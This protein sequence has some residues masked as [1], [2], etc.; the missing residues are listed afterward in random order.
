VRSSSM[1][2]ACSGRAVSSRVAKLVCPSCVGQWVAT[3]FV[4]GLVPRP[5]ATRLVASVFA[6]LTAADFL[7]FAY[8]A[9]EKTESS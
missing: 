6:A 3:G 1:R 2:P 5:R 4:F 7:Q 9:A 8:A